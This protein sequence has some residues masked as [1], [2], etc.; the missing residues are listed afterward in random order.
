MN[1]RDLGG[2][3]QSPP[4][5]RNFRYIQLTAHVPQRTERATAGPEVAQ[6]C[7]N[8]LRS[9]FGASVGAVIFDPEVISYGV[10]ESDTSNDVNKLAR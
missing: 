1:P 4:K 8:L 3:V 2:G 6:V 5:L 10:P 9:V 7:F